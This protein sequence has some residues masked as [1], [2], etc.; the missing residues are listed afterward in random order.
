MNPYVASLTAL[1]FALFAQ[2]L[3]AVLAL[4]GARES[5][6][7]RQRRLAWLALALAATLLTIDQFLALELAVRTGLYDLRRALLA[8]VT[9]AVF[10]LA[11]F[12]LRQR[13][14]Q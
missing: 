3:A 1:V 12:G 6:A 14:A 10:C 7:P 8:T 13:P 9:A 4:E 11:V 5:A 2:A